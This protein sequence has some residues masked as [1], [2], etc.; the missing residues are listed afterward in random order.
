MSVIALLLHLVVMAGAA[1]LLAGAL[2]VLRALLSRR[3]APPLLQPWRDWRR[4]LRKA[5]VVTAAA[6]PAML[7]APPACLAVTAYVV[8]LVPSFTMGMATAALSD[9]LVIA[10]LLGLCRVVTALAAIDAGTAPS[11]LA[12]VRAMQLGAL[13]LP[14]LLTASLAVA[15]L[16]GTTNLDAALAPLRETASWPVLLAAC[17]LAV[18]AVAVE[19]EDGGPFAE[20]S[21][22]HLAAAEATVALRRVAWLTLIADLLTP[23][24]MAAAGAGVVSWLAGLLAWAAKLAVLGVGCA[25]AGPALR[26]AGERAVARAMGAALLLALLAVLF[27]VAGQPVA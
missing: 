11:G 1:V 2:P 21:G 8:C 12:G 4:L 17:G 7:A 18:V 13:A 20:L 22:W 15:L 16:T 10:G 26:R 24:G 23:A 9:L 19:A 5:P 25:A 6:T 14:A 27:L 3:A